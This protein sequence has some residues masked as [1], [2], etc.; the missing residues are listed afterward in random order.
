MK[1]LRDTRGASLMFIL[2]ITF[3]LLS[4]GVSVLTAAG[5]NFGATAAQRD[6]SQLDIYVSGMERVMQLVIDEEE[7]ATGGLTRPISDART[8]VG[9]IL[10]EVLESAVPKREGSHYETGSIQLS[11]REGIDT[12][13]L[14]SASNAAGEELL[15]NVDYDV[16][17][18]WNMTVSVP[19]LMRCFRSV[20][21]F[22]DVEI[23]RC[24]LFA[25]GISGFISSRVTTIYTNP[26]GNV[27]TMTT[28][29]TYK[30]DEVKAEE[31]NACLFPNVCNRNSYMGTS[32]I[33]NLIITNLP[34]R[35]FIQHE[36]GIS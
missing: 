32:E 15:G 1:M 13:T 28:I 16:V 6:R 11:S 9:L 33:N 18:S 3:L 14:P 24:E 12:I 19:E 20:D 30:L 35:S 22:G 36:K 5:L 4:I 17:I 26:S 25:V 21:V 34:Q 31:I 7:D 29:T 10:Y 23:D 2:A 27:Y 8:L